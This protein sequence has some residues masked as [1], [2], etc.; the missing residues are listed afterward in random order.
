MSSEDDRNPYL[1]LLG[2]ACILMAISEK[3][4]TKILIGTVGLTLAIVLIE[5]ISRRRKRKP[6]VIEVIRKSDRKRARR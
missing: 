1:D 6:E 3:Y 4:F 2:I 5:Y